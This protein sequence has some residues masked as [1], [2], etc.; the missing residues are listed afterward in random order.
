MSRVRLTSICA[1]RSA[2]SHWPP[3]II[4]TPLRLWPLRCLHDDCNASSGFFVL[5]RPPACCRS[6]EMSFTSTS[7]VSSGACPFEVEVGCC[8]TPSAVWM[9]LRAVLAAGALQRPVLD[10]TC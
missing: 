10:E 1:H 4:A 8:A 2:P 6:A 3:T 9:S 5:P 7:A